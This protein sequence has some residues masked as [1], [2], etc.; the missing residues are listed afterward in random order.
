[1]AM[2]TRGEAIGDS[3][4]AG[5]RGSAEGNDSAPGLEEDRAS[6]QD[7]DSARCLQDKGQRGPVIGVQNRVR[8]DRSRGARGQA[9][10][11]GREVERGDPRH[12]QPNL[13]AD[14]GTV[15]GRLVAH[16]VGGDVPGE[17]RVTAV[18][19]T[20]C[21]G[22]AQTQQGFETASGESVLRGPASA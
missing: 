4:L 21:A 16:V 22:K 10:V 3:R 6:V 8:V 18:V 15:G 9:V 7:F 2:A 11:P 19:T 12:V 17:K 5:L 14:A 13:I 20:R 1:L